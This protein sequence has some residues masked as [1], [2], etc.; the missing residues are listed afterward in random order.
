MNR[1]RG[2]ACLPRPSARSETI[3]SDRRGWAGGP[4]SAN[5]PPSRACA[6]WCCK[7]GHTGE[8]MVAAARGAGAGDSGRREGE[9]G[10]RPPRGGQVVSGVSARRELEAVDPPWRP[11][12]GVPTPS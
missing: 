11:R 7:N 3:E 8:I 1:I 10:G 4:T 12:A 6:G 9:T 5:W 2:P